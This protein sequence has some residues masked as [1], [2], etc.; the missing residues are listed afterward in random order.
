[1]NTISYISNIV[2]NGDLLPALQL[3]VH[4]CCRIQLNEL[5]NNQKLYFGL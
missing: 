4:K 3:I 5:Q 1:M 2:Q